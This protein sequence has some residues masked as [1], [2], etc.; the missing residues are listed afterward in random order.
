MYPICNSPIN[1]AKTCPHFHPML[2]VQLVMFVLSSPILPKAISCS[3][4]APQAGAM[5][6][7]APSRRVTIKLFPVSQAG[8]ISN[9]FHP[10]SQVQFIIQLFPMLQTQLPIQFRPCTRGAIHNPVPVLYPRYSNSCAPVQHCRHNSLYYPMPVLTWFTFQ[11]QLKCVVLIY[12]RSLALSCF[13]FTSPT[14]AYIFIN[15]I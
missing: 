14:F 15:S 9:P 3:G 12:H 13:R 2:Q 8:T 11:I 1:L 7:S 10:T 5:H 4:P 6:N